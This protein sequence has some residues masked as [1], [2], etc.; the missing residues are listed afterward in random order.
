[1]IAE[2]LFRATDVVAPG[3][4]GSA[5][6]SNMHRRSLFHEEKPKSCCPVAVGTE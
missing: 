2:A 3:E 4:L 5:A 1:M 6:R